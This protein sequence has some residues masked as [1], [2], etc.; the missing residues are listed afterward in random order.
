M[1]PRK[2]TP[3]NTVQKPE[4]NLQAMLGGQMASAPERHP[5]GEPEAQP[6][7]DTASHT[8]SRM[9]CQQ[10]GAMVKVTYRL[11]ADLV[12]RLRHAYADQSTRLERRTMS[13]MVAEALSAYLDRAKGK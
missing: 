6:S 10:D 4:D 11:P 13:D 1:A 5:D 8:A 7:G 2:R 12:R 9:A 3:D